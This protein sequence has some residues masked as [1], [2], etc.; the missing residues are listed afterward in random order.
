MS[1]QKI[2]APSAIAFV[3]P[4]LVGVVTGIKAGIRHGYVRIVV[5]IV[6]A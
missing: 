4:V 2:I 6:D 1:G 5:R 3:N